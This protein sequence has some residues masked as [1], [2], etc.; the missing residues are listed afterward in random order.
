MSKYV[1]DIL[2]DIKENPLA[3]S[4]AMGGVKKD[5]IL[6]TGMGNTA[7]LSIV[8]IHIDGQY[9][10]ASYYDLF[11][12]ERAINKWYRSVPLTHLSK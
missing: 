10:P 11:K 7:L 6:I 1:D 3:W 5:N 4:K 2:Q 9:V 8:D 12:I